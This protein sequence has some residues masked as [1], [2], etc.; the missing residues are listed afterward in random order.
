MSSLDGKD[1]SRVAAGLKATMHNPNVSAEAK[2]NAAQ[3]LEEIGSGGI[4]TGNAQADDYGDYDESG[5]SGRQAGGYK[6]TLS[7]RSSQRLSRCHSTQ[8]ARTA[9]TRTRALRPSVMLKRS[10]TLESR[11]RLNLAGPTIYTRRA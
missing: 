6:A 11:P 1:P 9:Q 8:T 3:R 7:S 2:E 5:L 4:Q 10:S